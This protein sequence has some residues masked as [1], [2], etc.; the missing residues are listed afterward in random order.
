MEQIL[1]RGAIVH[2]QGNST[3]ALQ[4]QATLKE[5]A[6]KS[7]SFSADY[8]LDILAGLEDRGINIK[9]PR[10]VHKFLTRYPNVVPHLYD[11]AD[12]IA[13]LKTS[14]NFTL[15]VIT[16]KEAEVYTSQDLLLVIDTRLELSEAKQLVSDIRRNWL[17]KIKEPEMARF[18][19]VL[20]FG[21]GI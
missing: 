21:Y 13:K 1:S 16:D 5:V 8:L 15:K 19:I 10:N 3:W 9:E 14:S 18:S 17:Y 7:Y 11:L 2:F 12:Q 4:S 20:Q 6:N